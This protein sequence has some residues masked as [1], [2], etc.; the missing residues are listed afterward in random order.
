MER[1]PYRRYTYTQQAEHEGEPGA[2]GETLILQGIVS[3]VVLVA[4]MLISIVSFAP[5]V[6]VQ[7]AVRQALSGPATAGEL[8]SSAREFGAEV[9]HLPWLND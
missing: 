7:D 5:A 4:V 2:L 1:A 6:P 8:V 9:L 3:G